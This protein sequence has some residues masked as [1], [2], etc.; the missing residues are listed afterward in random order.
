MLPEPEK[1]GGFADQVMAL[2]KPVFL[3][4]LFLQHDVEAE[5]AGDTK[6]E[7]VLFGLPFTTAFDAPARLLAAR[8]S[9]QAKGGLKKLVN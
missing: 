6:Q 1:I 2:D 4:L 7:N 9:Q 8:A 3:G 5:R